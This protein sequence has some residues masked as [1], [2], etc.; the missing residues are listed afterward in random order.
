[1]KRVALLLSLLAVLALIVATG[2]YEINAYQHVGT[3]LA[4]GAGQ[5]PPPHPGPVPPLYLA[6]GAG[7]PP[8]PH[9]GP[10][11]PLTLA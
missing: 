11:P 8:P 3:S 1:M 4:D 6:D 10:V 7:Q 9:P 5:P 2:S